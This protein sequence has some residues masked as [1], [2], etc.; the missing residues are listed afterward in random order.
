MIPS[1]PMIFCLLIQML[2]HLLMPQKV[3]PQ[4]LA[5][6]PSIENTHSHSIEPTSDPPT[7][8]VSQTLDASPHET[9][10]AIE[11]ELHPPIRPLRE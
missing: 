6:N 4:Q 7:Q 11:P 5:T 1:S 9:Q 8:L 10:L 3:T 2:I